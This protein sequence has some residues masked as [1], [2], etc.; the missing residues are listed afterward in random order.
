VV[1]PDCE[2]LRQTPTAN[3][4]S[5]L[6]RISGAFMT[7]QIDFSALAALR[8]GEAKEM[9]ARAL[10]GRWREPASHQEGAVKSIARLHGF[11]AQIDTSGHIGTIA[12]REPFSK[13][14]EVA[15]LR[16]GM[17]LKDV[18]AKR[19]DLKEGYRLPVY[20]TVSYSADVSSH[21]KLL[22]EFRWGELYQIGFRNP[23]AV[24]PA[25][26]PMSYPAPVGVPG[27][28][29]ADPNFKL[30]VLSSLVENDVLDLAGYEDLARFVL[31][32]PVDLEKEGYELIPEAY[33]YLVRYPLSESDLALVETI[34]FDGGNEIYSYCFRF[35][36]G[37]TEEF[38]V[39]SLEGIAHCANLRSLI[40]IAV[41]EKLDIAQ[42]V[43]LRKLEEINLAEVCIN[44][45][46][47]LDLPALK[48]LTFH[49]GVIA[50]PILLA[51]LR[52]KGVAIKILR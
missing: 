27:T 25:K 13:E 2:I 45:D 32:R 9:L 51:R 35:W 7:A 33:D 11:Q 29:F 36:N 16:L 26:Q 31:K 39:K 1:E 24:Y 49:E 5:L 28:P 15:G 4:S 47:L 43:G 17:A 44:A 18:L 48:K 20:E 50:D 41:I 14:I 38:E 23:Q 22:L 46:R 40:C 8:P 21:Y 19:K 42:L 12:F 10:G 3:A 52:A 37:E 30:A 34:T 6:K